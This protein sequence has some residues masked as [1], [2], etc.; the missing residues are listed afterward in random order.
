MSDAVRETLARIGQVGV[1][2]V[3][4]LPDAGAAKPLAAALMRAGLPIAEVSFRTGA[5][6]EG[7]A[8][9]RR[10]QPEML[11]GAGTV[12]TKAQA[13]EAIQAGARFVVSPGLDPAVVD[14]CLELGV[15]VMPGI[16][17]A[18]ELTMAVNRGLSAVK[19]FPAEPMGGLKTLKALAGPFADVLFMPTGGVGPQNMG[20]YLAWKRILAVGG[21]WMVA[22]ELLC[23]GRYDAVEHLAREAVTLAHQARHGG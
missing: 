12:L 4:S 21:S 22:G 11:V 17:T 15:T 2:P 7:I 8:A 20:A 6:L 19:F 16:C 10:S 14:L 5:T 18:S 3:I 1:M 13:R 9:M 23:G